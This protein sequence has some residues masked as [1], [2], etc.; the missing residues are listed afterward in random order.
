[1]AKK[2]SQGG[3]LRRSLRRVRAAGA[4]GFT[5]VELMVVVVIIAIF[6]AIAIPAVL[7]A[8]QDRKAFEMAH[9][10]AQLLQ[11]ARAHAIATGSAH[12]VVMTTSGYGSSAD[13]GTFLVYQAFFNVAPDPN[14]G[15]ASS[16][17]I[18]PNQWTA[19]PAAP[20][21]PPPYP[22]GPSAALVDGLNYAYSAD[23][24]LRSQFVFNGGA[25]TN[26]AALCFTP[27]GRVYYAANVAGIPT[28]IPLTL[29]FEIQMRRF[30]T[31][32]A[33]GT[34][35]SVTIDSGDLAR[36]RTF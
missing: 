23:S 7:K 12:L 34:T 25:A 21:V 13:M 10:T 20:G 27:G 36:V 33:V 11:S 32:V 15:T 3:G 29:P 4:R 35:R 1:L 9:R 31:G 24:P 14:N 8:S 17:C 28:A 22:A 5:L 6:A 19:L 16:N 30:D 26:T 18:M 2:R